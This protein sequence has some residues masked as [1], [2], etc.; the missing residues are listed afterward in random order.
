L[1]CFCNKYGV[2]NSYGQLYQP[3]GV[4]E[5]EPICE[6][7]FEMSISSEYLS[8]AISYGIIILNYVLRTFCISIIVKIGRNTESKEM[9]LISEC[10]FLLTFFNTGILL[11]VVYANF[12][13][14]ST[15]LGK[16]MDGP[17]CD[18]TMSWFTLIGTTLVSSMQ[19]N[20]YYPIVEAF[21]YWFL[22]IVYRQLDRGLSCDVNKTKTISHH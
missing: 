22:R 13:E 5:G 19:F 20:V 6:E 1:Q 10:V 18:F 2:D 7:Y 14:Q 17:L 4:S 12:S 8:E 11:L 16:I 15:F 21:G 3:D 9:M